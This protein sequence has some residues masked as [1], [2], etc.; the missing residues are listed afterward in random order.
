MTTKKEVLEKIEVLLKD[1]NLKFDRL[2][3]QEDINILEYELFEINAIYFSEHCRILRKITES[4]AADSSNENSNSL[5]GASIS[6][7]SKNSS[8]DLQNEEEP[9]LVDQENERKHENTPSFDEGF[10][11]PTLNSSTIDAE[12]NAESKIE[13]ELDF[14]AENHSS[15]S[16]TKLEDKPKDKEDE[17]AKAVEEESRNEG[18]P[19]QQNNYESSSSVKV[20]NVD[21]TSEESRTQEV[22]Q[23]EVVQEVI[24]EEK[25][26]S[27]KVE[28][29]ID[30]KKELSTEAAP[31]A[32]SIA[33]S[34]S[35]SQPQS[36]NDRMSA[37]RQSSNKDPEAA[38]RTFQKPKDIKTFI[39][40]NDKLIF[41][42]ELFNGYSLAY[43][44]ALE[45]LN[46]Y[47]SYEKAKEFLHNNYAEKNNWVSKK[48]TADKFYSVLK[49]RYL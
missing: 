31:I 42:K 18:Q 45:L 35:T 41:I 3:A 46:R 47:D 15:E 5:N 32:R 40:L 48:E 1:I 26:F 22:V 20:S 2:A 37:L 4:N 14:P 11:E 36:L 28:E 43:S 34:Y 30:N 9:V 27:F 17:D 24:V 21:K 25:E 13:S 19:L 12:S 49:K 39:N 16:E 38:V 29:E 23:Q 33:E 8:E 10:N 44:E 6:S 7:E